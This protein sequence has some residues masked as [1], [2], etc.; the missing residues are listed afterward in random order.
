MNTW[1]AIM[2]ALHFSSCDTP[3][4]VCVTAEVVKAY[5]NNQQCYDDLYQDTN[6]T[7]YSCVMIHGRQLP[8]FSH[9]PAVKA[10][11]PTK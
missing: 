10:W 7:R 1:Y 11:K 5:I 9:Q 6:T 8:D 4:G 2:I 3:A